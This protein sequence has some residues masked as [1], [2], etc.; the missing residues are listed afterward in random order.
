M[1]LSFPSSPSNG[2]TYTHGDVTYEFDGKR[3]RSQASSID[4]SAYYSKAEVDARIPST[5]GFVQQSQLN[6]AIAGINTTSFTESNKTVQFTM[7]ASNS[8]YTWS[9]GLPA[10][11][12]V[13]MSVFLSSRD[14]DQ[15]D[16]YDIKIGPSANYGSTWGDTYP[17]AIVPYGFGIVTH[18]GD[19]QSV[20]LGYY[21]FWDEVIAK[22]N[23]SGQLVFS[24]VGSNGGSGVAVRTKGYW[25]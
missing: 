24:I 1:A 12:W 25:S 5:A 6:S 10:N 11:T 14:S 9:A 8:S 13:A 20:A 2:Q 15:S 18:P 17:S 23:A 4:L 7:G 21:G 22:T 19:N 16:H 3:W